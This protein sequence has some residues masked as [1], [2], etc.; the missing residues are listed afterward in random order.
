MRV[1]DRDWRRAFA[2]CLIVVLVM[3][4]TPSPIPLPSTGWDKA[5]HVLAFTVLAVL[6]C[7]AYPQRATW[8]VLAGLFAY[9]GAIELLQLLTASRTAEWLDLAA[10]GAGL[11]CGWLLTCARARVPRVK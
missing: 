7:L 4:L 2:A 11:S 10:D 8:V 9:G 6:G 5:N 1:K 3:A